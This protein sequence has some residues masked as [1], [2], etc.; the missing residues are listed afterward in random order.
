QT[1]RQVPEWLAGVYV[2]GHIYG[3]IKIPDMD[4]LLVG[5]GPGTQ[6]TGWDSVSPADRPP[7]VWL[8]H[9]CFDVMVG[10]GFLLLLAGLWAAWT[11]W[12]RRR[13]PRPRLFWAAGGG[14]RAADHCAGGHHQ[15]W[16]PRQLEHH[17]RGVR[18]T[19][20]R[21]DRDLADVVPP[22]APRRR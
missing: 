16:R 18:G 1:S 11:W 9:L 13:W 17:H 14:V 15:R 4:S 20:H 2:N 5:F 7:V 12:R 22:L 19:G 10:L 8:I 3:G 21:H 6:V